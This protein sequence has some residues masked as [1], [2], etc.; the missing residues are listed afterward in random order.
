[1]RLAD[2]RGECAEGGQRERHRRDDLLGSSGDSTGTPTAPPPL[3]AGLAG[4][5]C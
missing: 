1:V 3:A 5:L 4:R 2:A